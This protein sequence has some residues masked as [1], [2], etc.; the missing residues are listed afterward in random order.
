MYEKRNYLIVPITEIS[1]VDFT[2]VCET[3][4][5]TLRKTVDG[6]KTFVKW[7]GEEIPKF[8]FEIVGYEGP[9][10]HEKILE[11]LSAPEWSIPM[12]K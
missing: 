6:N 12:E 10:S 8:V 9:F 2:Q 5:E 3:S 4:L 11:I 1:K 7:E